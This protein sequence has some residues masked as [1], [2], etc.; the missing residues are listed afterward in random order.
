M[1]QVTLSVPVTLKRRVLSS[2]SAILILRS[3]LA[4][5]IRTPWRQIPI[6]G[7]RTFTRGGYT[8]LDTRLDDVHFIVDHVGEDL[9][10]LEEVHI[11]T[12]ELY[13]ILEEI[14]QRS[15][16]CVNQVC[17]CA[18]PCECAG[19]N[20]CVR[21]DVFTCVRDQIPGSRKES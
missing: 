7:A 2:D 12:V 3:A 10:E 4:L 6:R 16:R 18:C 14:L 5:A 13:R 9:D 8:L 17:V 1:V 11:M 15:L 21:L 20:A 19:V